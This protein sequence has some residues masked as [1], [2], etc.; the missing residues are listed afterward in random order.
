MKLADTRTADRAAATPLPQLDGGWFL[1]DGGIETVLIYQDGIPL[2][3]FAAFTLL[4]TAEG[5]DQLRRYFRRYLD[6]AVATPGAGFILESPTWRAGLDWGAKLGFDARAMERVN[7]DAVMLMQELRNAYASRI[8]GAI[9]VSGCIGPRGDGYV[10]GQPMALDDART[11]HQPQVDVLAAAGVDM[12]S[13]ITMT[14]SAE[15]IGV[16]RAAARADRPVAVSFTL[17]TDGRLP[18][19]ESL[20][21]AIDAVEQDAAAGSH[22]APAYFMLNCLH[23]TH[24]E[25]VLAALGDRR[26][27]I[28][29]L[30]ANASTLSHA[31]LDV[32]TEL[33]DGDPVALGRDYRRLQNLLPAL[34]VLGGCCG[35]DHRH[36]ASMSML[37]RV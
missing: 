37:A 7:T 8:D 14:T 26:S 9:V 12:I 15:A 11:V 19:G 32:M 35:T 13:A 25:G 10:A 28:R 5:P 29:G 20:A 4:R 2:P 6:I 22:A 1:T 30:R 21:E 33:D 17:D 36:V 16:T 23:P 18:S 31:E 34:S 3:E 27:R 24:A